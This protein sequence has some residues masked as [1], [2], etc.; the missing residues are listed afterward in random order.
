[1]HVSYCVFF[2]W[3]AVHVRAST[4]VL[5]SQV[6]TLCVGEYVC[7][8]VFYTINYSVCGSFLY[9]SS[10]FFMHDFQQSHGEPLLLHQLRWQVQIVSLI[11]IYSFCY[12]LV[13]IGFAK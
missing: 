9:I 1:M 8:Y 10:A 4:C 2:G 3:I 12:I 6:I 11:I 13:A 7:S 5:P